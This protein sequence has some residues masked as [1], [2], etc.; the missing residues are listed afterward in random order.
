MSNSYVAVSDLRPQS[1]ITP[2][3]GSRW[4]DLYVTTLQADDTTLTTRIQAASD[5]IERLTGDT[6][7][8]GTYTY[9]AGTANAPDFGL[10]VLDG[11]PKDGFGRGGL[12]LFTPARIVTFNNAY[13]LPLNNGSPVLVPTVWYKVHKSNQAY[14]PDDYD[15]V[16]LVQ[17]AYN[18]SLT[19]VGAGTQGFAYW[20]T[21][22]RSIGL[23]GV[24]G[25]SSIPD[26]IARATAKIVVAWSTNRQV[27]SGVT[28]YTAGGVHFQVGAPAGGRHGNGIPWVTGDP[29]VDMII[30]VYGRNDST[31]IPV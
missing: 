20:W 23:D 30:Q 2:T 22:A 14:R 6:Y 3:T 11:S 17:D 25:W 26:A 27:P 29:E 9:A 8:A 15:A 7:M 12:T 19:G 1:S 28:E 18:P 31:P 13:L 4:P 10:L 16:E 21:W 5:Y 24:F